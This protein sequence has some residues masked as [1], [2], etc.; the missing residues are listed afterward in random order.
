VIQQ[1]P[2]DSPPQWSGVKK[3]GDLRRS[4]HGRDRA[5]GAKEANPDD[6]SRLC[7]YGGGGYPSAV[8][9]RTLKKA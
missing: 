7:L 3:I 5:V 1:D 6:L 2:A 9:S 8:L 4:R